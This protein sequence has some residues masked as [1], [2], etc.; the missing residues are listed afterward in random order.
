MVRAD[1]DHV[2]LWIGLAAAIALLATGVLRSVL[3]LLLAGAAGLFQWTPQIALFYLED[4]L[5][6]E[7]TLFVIGVLLIAMAGLLTRIY[8]RGGF[9]PHG[10]AGGGSPPRAD[11]GRHDRPLTAAARNTRMPLQLLLGAGVLALLF[12]TFMAISFGS[13]ESDRPDLFEDVGP[14]QPEAWRVDMSEDEE[15][16]HTVVLIKTFRPLDE[17]AIDEVGG[18]LLWPDTR[19]ELCGVGVRAVGDGFVQIGDIFA[20]HEDCDSDPPM[21]QTF[22]EQGPPD[23]ACLHVVADGIYDEYCAPLVI[24]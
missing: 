2:G 21:Q 17:A 19:V 7:A 13:D 16:T 24:E 23:S 3:E 20:S 4:T 22:D 6:A 15:A 9:G 5:G 8:P 10:R 18:R 11:G 14:V 1:N 12:V